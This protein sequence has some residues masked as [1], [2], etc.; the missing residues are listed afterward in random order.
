M[1]FCN[2]SIEELP[3]VV[4]LSSPDRHFCFDAAHAFK[5]SKEKDFNLCAQV[6][7]GRG[8]RKNDDRK[9]LMCKYL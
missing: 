2:V 1:I 7:N 4:T 6:D 8:D 5:N 9:I 3:P